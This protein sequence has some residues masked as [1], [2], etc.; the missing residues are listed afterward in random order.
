MTMKRFVAFG[1]AWFSLSFCLGI[2]ATRAQSHAAAPAADPLSNINRL[3]ADLEQTVQVFSTNVEGKGFAVARG[4]WTLW[5]IEDCKYP[6]QT[7]CNKDEFVATKTVERV[8]RGGVF[9]YFER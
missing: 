3:P 9:R 5:G 2:S 1:L 6:I 7:L 8:S 4:Y